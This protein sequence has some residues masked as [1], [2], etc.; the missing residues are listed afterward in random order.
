[1]NPI[2]H[3]LQL[4][5]SPY[6]KRL[7]FDTARPVARHLPAFIKKAIRKRSSPIDYQEWIKRH[8]TLTD[9]DREQILAHIKTF[10]RPPLFSVPFPLKNQLYP[11]L[12]QSESGDFIVHVNSEDELA[13]HALYLAAWE[14][15]K[16]PDTALIYA[17]ED[18]IDS[19]GNRSNPYFKPDW[20]PDL[21]LAHNY[22]GKFKI[23]RRDRKQGPIRHIPAVLYHRR[24][25]V[26]PYH[27]PKFSVAG[28][29]L[30]SIIIPTRNG[31]EFLRPCLESL[32]KTAYKH[33]EVIIIDNQSDDLKTLQ[34]LK[35]ISSEVRVL[36]YPYPFNYAAM[37]NWVVPHAKG[38]YLCLLNND[39]E[40]ISPT[41]L[42]EMLA[43]AQRPVTGAVGAKLLYSDDT[44]QHGGVILGLGGPAEH[45]NR[46]KQRDDAGYFGRNALLQNF[47]AVTAAC[48]LVKKS[49]WEELGGM[50]EELSIGFNDIDFCLRLQE[51][52]WLNTWAPQSLLY[53]H[54]SKTRGHDTSQEKQHRAALE[55][56]YMQWRWGQLIQRDPAYNPNLSLQKGGDFTL[57]ESPRF[58][59][60]WREQPV[61][62]DLQYGM[63]LG[64]TQSYASL[65]PGKDLSGVFLKPRGLAG[66]LVGV[67]FHVKRLGGQ[68]RGKVKLT[69]SGA[70]TELTL[71]DEPQYKEWMPLYF[72]NTPIPLIDQERLHFQLSLHDA[73]HPLELAA[74]ALNQKWGHGIDGLEH[75][76]LRMILYIK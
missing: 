43:L 8:D 17:D 7:L 26:E 63:P 44:V 16:D 56:T 65:L 10:K 1:M 19:Q 9:K 2:L 61:A 32:A 54:E 74:Y 6:R 30:V 57:A 55:H 64:K 36:S 58:I 49:K 34:Y 33:Y 24:S 60:P 52:G 22:I 40:V 69:L 21:M 25:P 59:C 46:G 72:D 20:N 62:F 42:E 66:Q 18:E 53:H 31:L 35:E 41:W 45:V 28:E 73:R 68:F 48:M 39:I 13:E 4:L 14:I 29:P 37:H 5:K 76:A 51:K 47:S 23:E 15:E 67:A 3:S 71:S 38:E 11:Y 50:T 75:L 70:T 12:E 27:E